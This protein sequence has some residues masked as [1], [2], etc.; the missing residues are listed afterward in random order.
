MKLPPYLFV[1]DVE[2]VGLH[3]EG[4]A[5]GYVVVSTEARCT[6]KAGAFA[7]PQ[8]FA[9]GFRH[10]REW[11]KTHVSVE[12]RDTVMLDNPRQV[13]ERFWSTWREWQ[14]EGAVLF[15]DC[16]WPVEAR[17]LAACVADARMERSIHGPYPLHE[18]ASFRLAAGFDPL[19]TELR[20]PIE[21]PAHDP[22][23]DAIQSARLLLE[24]IEVLKQGA[25]N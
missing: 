1:I 9:I 17:F 5:V 15:A 23:R 24:A 22:L 14:S 6:V 18:I 20:L 11:V 25:R 7:C 12:P 8:D 10:D 3:G 13:R 4:F 2:S 19:A 16:G 21:L